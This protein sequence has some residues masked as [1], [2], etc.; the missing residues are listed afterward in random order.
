VALLRKSGG[1]TEA[2]IVPKGGSSEG[3]EGALEKNRSGGGG[4]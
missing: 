2:L 4:G 3:R 1:V